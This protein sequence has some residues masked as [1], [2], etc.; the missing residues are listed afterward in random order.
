MC[1]AVPAR[2]LSVDGLVA[3]VERYGERLQVSLLL[4]DQ[5][6]AEGDHLILQ[7]QRY[8]V[9]KLDAAAAADAYRLFDQVIGRPT[10]PGP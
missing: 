5:P 1:I 6:V 9:E 2:V 10:D 8:A 3:E 7:A 4:L